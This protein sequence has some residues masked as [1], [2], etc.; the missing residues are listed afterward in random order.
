MQ[1]QLKQK[2]YIFH[3]NIFSVSEADIGRKT[4]SK[5]KAD[6][7][8]RSGLMLNIRRLSEMKETKLNSEQKLKN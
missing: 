6:S 4:L 3:Y 1:K 7:I 2:K 8:F 5:T